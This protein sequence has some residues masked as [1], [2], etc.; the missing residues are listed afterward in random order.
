MARLRA[1]GGFTLVEMMSA[2]VIAGILA[3]VIFRL[4]ENQSRFVATQGARQEAQQNARGALDIM[5]G[6]LRTLNPDGLIEAEAQ[7]LTFMLPRGWG[8]VC[9]ST[10]VS[11]TTIDVIFPDL[12]ADA[13]GPGGSAGV[14][15]DTAA[16]DSS[17]WAPM[18]VV[19]AGSRAVVTDTTRIDLAGGGNACADASSDGT[20]EA[21]TLSG[22]RFP[23]ERRTG[24]LVMLYQLVK[25]DVGT[26]DG[27]WWVRRSNGVSGT[28]FSQQPLA[29]P[30][31][32]QDSMSFTYYRGTNAA[33]VVPGTTRATLDDVSRIRIRVAM[34]GRNTVGGRA[35]RETD[36]VTVL[37]R[38][39]NRRITN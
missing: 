39:R 21:F 11:T 24:S 35:Q 38:N 6:E 13:F 37:L 1:R 33:T 22:A 34:E 4:V 36:S 9:N 25:Y 31:A 10:N 19:D 2:L 23:A 18:A 7:S 16:G 26:S 8:V 28:T 5:A 12:P 17:K 27:K 14:L 3:T 29:G 30:L 15:V 32:A 20:A